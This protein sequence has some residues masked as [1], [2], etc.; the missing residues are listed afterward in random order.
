MI[1]KYTILTR[2]IFFFFFLKLNPFTNSMLRQ[3]DLRNYLGTQ[4][5][6][7]A[8]IQEPLTYF[9]RMWRALQ[10]QLQHIYLTILVLCRFILDY[11]TLYSNYAQQKIE[12]C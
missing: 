4:S 9:D 8:L 12:N 11:L 5:N 6:D 7:N 1:A 3:S 2:A 10:S